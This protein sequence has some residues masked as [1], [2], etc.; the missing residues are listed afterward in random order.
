MSRK[1]RELF[2]R[3]KDDPKTM[4]AIEA[5][6]EGMREAVKAIAPGLTL[7]DILQDVG[8]ELKQMGAH[9]AHELAATLF[10]GSPFVMYPRAGH[11]NVEDPQH[12]LPAEQTKE[13]DLG[14]EM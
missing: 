11:D 6:V 10:N 5:A 14:R 12:G 9:G 2:D 13:H 7:K 4:G 3:L 1:T 8:A